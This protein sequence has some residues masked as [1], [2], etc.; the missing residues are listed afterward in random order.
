MSDSFNRDS[1]DENEEEEEEEEDMMMMS[2]KKERAKKSNANSESKRN[3]KGTTSNEESH[4]GKSSFN[5]STMDQFQR[6]TNKKREYL[7]EA[8]IDKNGAYLY[9]E[10]P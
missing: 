9:D 10:D 5:E 7:Q 3:M 2:G 4:V 1:K 6:L 8:I